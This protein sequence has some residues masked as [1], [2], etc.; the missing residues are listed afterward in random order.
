M[1][2]KTMYVLAIAVLSLAA[3]KNEKKQEVN[4]DATEETMTKE[5][6]KEED[7]HNADGHDHGS[8]TTED[9]R[10]VTGTTEKNAATSQII[11]SYLQIKNGLVATDKADAA[12]GGEAMVTAFSNFDMTK[13]SG[14]T[15]EEYMEI[16]E[17]AK[18]HAE[19]I[20]KS[21]MAHQ[22]EHFEALSIDINDLVTLLGTDKTLY[23]DFCPMYND[24]KGAMWLSE[25]E[26]IKNPFYGSKMMKCGK[27]QKQI[28]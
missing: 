22:R 9:D 2:K 26:E 17:S 20:V 24:G 19:H 18:E 1:N 27:V 3:C 14:E 6:H 8:A 5:M 12:K 10:N 16:L 11:D 21:D 13:L 15:H 7:G 25:T 4:P 28:N 23:Q